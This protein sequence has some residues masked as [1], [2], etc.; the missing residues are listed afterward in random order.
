[1]ITNRVGVALRDIIAQQTRLKQIPGR[2]PESFIARKDFNDIIE[3]CRITRGDKKDVA[4]RLEWWRAQ[5]EQ[6]EQEPLPPLSEPTEETG[7]PQRKKRRRRRR[8]PPGSKGPRPNSSAERE[9]P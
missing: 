7:A 2:R 6:L 8:K 9:T 4:R 3:Y 1:M 5:A